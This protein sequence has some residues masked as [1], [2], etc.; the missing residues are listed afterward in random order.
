MFN[1]MLNF[2]KDI[3]E[4]H[5][6]SPADTALHIAIERGFFRTTKK[7]LAMNADVNKLNCGY[8]ETPLHRAARY[9][10]IELINLLI[11]HGGSME[12]TD[13]GKQTPLHYACYFYPQ[14]EKVVGKCM[15][16]NSLYSRTM[17]GYTPMHTLA[18]RSKEATAE[19]AAIVESFL[20]RGFDMETKDYRGRTPLVSY[21][22]K[23]RWANGFIII[24]K[25]CPS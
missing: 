23:K 10:R 22:E 25:Q 5:G 24:E 17:K 20:G 18:S 7:I 13:T 15:E 21:L 1:F 2:M 9:Q 8:D 6:V 4:H 14:N 11:E 3:N 16:Y 19:A 12:K